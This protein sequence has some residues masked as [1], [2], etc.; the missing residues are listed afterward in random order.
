MHLVA[1]DPVKP[2]Q[3]DVFSYKYLGIIIYVYVTFQLVSD[4]TA[5]KI[6]DIFGLT[7]SAT[8]LYFPVTMIISDVL[9]EVYGYAQARRALWIVMG[10]SITAGLIYQ[11]VVFLP[12]AAGFDG[13]DAYARVLGQV[14][15]VLVGCW[16]AIFVGDIVNNYIMARMKVMTQGRWLWLRTITSTFVGQGLN[17][18]LFYVIALGGIIPTDLLIASIISGWLL[19]TLVEALFTP[20]T[21]LVVNHVKRVEG[22]DHYDVGTDFNPL[23]VK[24]AR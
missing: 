14:P 19:K 4:V 16:I 15:R 17:T 21:Y 5:G 12:P 3:A 8:A 18:V 2:A 22:I 6:V 1:A 23:R 11:L 10:A 13:N 24:T 20:L 7:V 9:T